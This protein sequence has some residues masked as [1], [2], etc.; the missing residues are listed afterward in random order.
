MTAP[1]ITYCQRQASDCARRARLASSPEIKAYQR[2]LGSQWI[3][4]AEKARVGESRTRSVP[5]TLPCV[6]GTAA[7][8]P[9][10]DALPNSAYL[11]KVRR[12]CQNIAVVATVIMIFFWW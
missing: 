1:Y 10:S 3:K 5:C 6:P 7:H 11:S 2:R 12:A 8:C 4:L 9:I